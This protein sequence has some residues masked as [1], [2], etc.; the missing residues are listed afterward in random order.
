MKL[1]KKI[2]LITGASSGIGAELARRAA[3]AGARLALVARRADRLEKLAAE[4]GPDTLVLAADLSSLEACCAAVDQTVDKLGGLDV[5]LLNAGISS[6]LPVAEVS[7]P[8]LFST[9]MQTNYFGPVHCA[10]R[11]LPH[12]RRSRGA[13]VV[14]S[15]LQGKAGFP[16]F[17]AYSAS[18]HALHGFFDSLRA[19]QDDVQITIACPGPVATEIGDGRPESSQKGI[20]SA[21]RCAEIIVAAVE[22][23]KRE[24]VMTAAGKLGVWLRP[25]LP[26]L[27]D[28]IVRKKTQRFFL[29]NGSG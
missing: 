27:F 2:V 25:F 12:L 23:G 10:W 20:M 4:C 3:A 5:L 1:A 17:A 15:S 9:V 22:S 18:K 13:I 24:V 21:G 28:R 29:K 19:E 26:G 8:A 14:V 16:G 6:N 7:D 11:A